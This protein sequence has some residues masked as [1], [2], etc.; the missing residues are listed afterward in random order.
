MMMVGSSK[1]VST[2]TTAHGSVSAKIN[3]GYVQFAP[4][5]GDLHRLAQ[6]QRIVSSGSW[7]SPRK[8]QSAHR[9]ENTEWGF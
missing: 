1:L 9:I 4:G 8:L 7:I 6:K 3:R 5:Y 2:M